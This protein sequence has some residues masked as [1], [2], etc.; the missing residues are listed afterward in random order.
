MNMWYPSGVQ[1]GKNDL[2]TT[3]LVSI[4]LSLFLPSPR[5][6]HLKTKNKKPKLWLLIPFVLVQE[7][8]PLITTSLSVIMFPLASPFCHSRTFFIPR[9][10]NTAEIKI[11]TKPKKTPTKSYCHEK[12][13]H[14]KIWIAYCDEP[15]NAFNCP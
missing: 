7:T 4:L 12:W 3:V 15:I 10:L 13:C 6:L 8:Y 1:L 14:E 5:W 9:K 11:K 2:R